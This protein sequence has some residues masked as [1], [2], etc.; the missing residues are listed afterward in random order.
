MPE[1][2]PCHSIYDTFKKAKTHKNVEIFKRPLSSE[3]LLS[4]P[5]PFKNEITF[6]PLKTPFTSKD[7]IQMKEFFSYKDPDKWR[8]L[9]PPKVLIGQYAVAAV[10]KFDHQCNPEVCL[11]VTRKNIQSESLRFR[12]KN[13]QSSGMSGFQILVMFLTYLWTRKRLQVTFRVT[14]R[15]SQS[16]GVL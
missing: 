1:F 13:F 16:L 12:Y 5:G 4:L 2:Q 8:T 15:K 9:S 10:C 7:P 3:R 11:I 14:N 6:S